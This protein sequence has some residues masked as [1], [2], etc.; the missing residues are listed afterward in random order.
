MRRYRRSR[1]KKAVGLIMVAK[2]QDRIGIRN[3]YKRTKD[4][5]SSGADSKLRPFNHAS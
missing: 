3:W 2:R 4:G 5:K 1:G